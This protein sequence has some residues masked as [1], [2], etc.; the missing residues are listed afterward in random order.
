MTTTFLIRLIGILCMLSVLAA[1]MAWAK[2]QLPDYLETATTTVNTAASVGGSYP[3]LADD[4]LIAK[5]SIRNAQAEYEKNLGTFSG[6]LDEKA[7]PIVRQLAETARLQAALVIAKAGARNQEKERNRLE[8]LIRA[9]QAKIKVF[10]DL[11]TQVRELK[12][13]TSDQ[14]AK[15]ASLE[16]KIASLEAELKAKGSAITSSDQKTANLLKA[17]DEQKKATASSEQRVAALTQELDTLKQQTARLQVSREQLAAEKRIKEFEAEVGKLG[18][19][20]K[21]T[22]AGLGITF[23]RAQLLKTTGKSTTLTPDGTTVA[24]KLVSLLKAYPEYRIKLRVHGFGQPARSED[25][26]AT[27]QMARFTRDWLL[28]K[29]RLDQDDVEALGVGAAE[30]LYPKNNVEGNRRVEIIFVKK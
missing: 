4:I 13:Q 24:T 30:P 11:V 9:T 17:L 28:E 27:D 26:A 2:G 12:K 5:N 20:V 6:K 21:P 3:E 8:S 19:I 15:I 10:D 23:P 18:G 7:E 22:T 29:G 14:T 1:P 16:A 25:T